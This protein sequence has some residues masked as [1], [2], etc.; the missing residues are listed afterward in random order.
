MQLSHI[1]QKIIFL[2]FLWTCI[3]CRTQK[4]LTNDRLSHTA[5]VIWNSKADRF[6]YLRDTQ[7]HQLYAATLQNL[8]L[9]DSLRKG[10]LIACSWLPGEEPT[11]IPL[12]AKHVQLIK[13]QKIKS[14]IPECAV[15]IDPLTYPWSLEIVRE[16]NPRKVIRFTYFNSYAYYFW[17]KGD[18]RLYDCRGTLMSY[19]IGNEQCTQNRD[20]T[21]GITIWTVQD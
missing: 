21:M 11:P 16:F 18:G 3:Q 1:S 14:S 4:H 15:F 17:R 20:L 12:N 5:Q 6:I 2:L 9:R 13:F 8:E 7:D 19:D 10:D